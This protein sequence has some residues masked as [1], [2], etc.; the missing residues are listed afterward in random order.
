MKNLEKKI[1]SKLPINGGKHE[2]SVNKIELKLPDALGGK[3]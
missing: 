1:E 2:K 3:T